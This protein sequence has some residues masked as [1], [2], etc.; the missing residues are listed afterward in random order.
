MLVV[1]DDADA[2]EAELVA[3]RLPCPGCGGPLGRYGWARWRSVRT[4]GAE[5]A[6][7]PRRGWCARC[8]AAHVLLPAWS[9]PRRRDAAEVIVAALVAKV[10]RGTGRSPLRWAARRLRCEAGCAERRPGPRPGLGAPRRGQERPSA[11]TESRR[12]A[13]ALLTPSWS[14]RPASRP[15]TV[16]RQLCCRACPRL[17]WFLFPVGGLRS[18]GRAPPILTPS[19][20]AILKPRGAQHLIYGGA[21][22]LAKTSSHLLSKGVIPLVEHWQP[23]ALAAAGIVGMLVI[24]SAFQAGALDASLPTMTV[25]DP[26]V[27]IAIGAFA[28]GESITT[29][30][31]SSIT[32]VVALAVMAGG[33]FVLARTEAELGA[34][35]VKA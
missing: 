13:P 4:L 7:R 17:A 29:G 28:F 27:S 21:A 10:A 31:A 12:D 11:A 34:R 19:D 23:W 16:A 15:W 24:Q 32:E 1:G 3:G 20:I 22:A 35:P 30:I 26:I 18:F 9:L 2:V 33:V 14:K 25:I 6:L 5:R 8:E